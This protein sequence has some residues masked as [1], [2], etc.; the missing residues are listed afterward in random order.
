[1]RFSYLHYSYVS[2]DM[3]FFGYN[4]VENDY[5]I[6]RFD[7][8]SGNFLAGQLIEGNSDDS[9]LASLEDQRVIVAFK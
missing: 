7:G 1:M 9:K 8:S 2:E 4:E 5:W 6:G 3:Y